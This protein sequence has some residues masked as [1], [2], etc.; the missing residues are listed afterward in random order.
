MNMATLNPQNFK[1]II[2]VIIMTNNFGVGFT[3]ENADC[4]RVNTFHL[5]ETMAEIQ[6]HLSSVSHPFLGENFA[7]TKLGDA[8]HG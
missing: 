2:I 3:S 1:T 8:T 4:G 5:A 7:S 6:N